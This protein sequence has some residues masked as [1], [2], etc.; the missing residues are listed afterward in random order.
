MERFEEY[1]IDDAEDDLVED[2]QLDIVLDEHGQ[3]V[4]QANP[5]HLLCVMRAGHKSA[6]NGEL[7]TVRPRTNDSYD[8][9]QAAILAE[10]QKDITFNGEALTPRMVSVCERAR[11]PQIS[12]VIPQD[13]VTALSDELEKRG[14]ARIRLKKCG[15][16]R[17]GRRRR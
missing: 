5:A 10:E 8:P 9:L 1:W 13:R 2:D 11:T 6:R 14:H 7:I 12:E 15:L 4:D 3:P 17:R 16:T